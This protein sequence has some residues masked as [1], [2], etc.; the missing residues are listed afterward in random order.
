MTLWICC[1]AWLCW[2]SVR[3]GEPT[4]K[5]V[6]QLNRDKRHEKKTYIEKWHRRRKQLNKTLQVSQHITLNQKRNHAGN[7]KCLAW[8]RYGYDAAS[9]NMSIF[10]DEDEANRTSHIKST[11]LELELEIVMLFIV[12]LPAKSWL[13]LPAP[14]HHP[15]NTT[16]KKRAASA[17]AALTFVH[18]RVPEQRVR[19]CDKV[20]VS[21]WKCVCVVQGHFYIVT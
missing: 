4:T 16:S 3:C 7:C 20:T 12:S 10:S 21:A 8:R 1:V 11:C 9:E 17:D 2:C 5:E 14:E 19:R 18:C 15:S 6:K 13:C